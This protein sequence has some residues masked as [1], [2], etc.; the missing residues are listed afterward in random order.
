MQTEPGRRT[1]AAS[2]RQEGGT[3]GRLLVRLEVVLAEAEND[4]RLAHGRL[5]CSHEITLVSVASPHSAPA[6]L[7]EVHSPV[8]SV[9]IDER[10]GGKAEVSGIIRTDQGVCT[11]SFRSLSG[12]PR[13]PRAT[14]RCTSLR[15]MNEARQ[16]RPRRS[17]AAGRARRTKEDKLDLHGTRRRLLGL[18]LLAHGEVPMD[19]AAKSPLLLEPSTRLQPGA[20]LTVLASTYTARAPRACT[21]GSPG[22]LC[23][24]PSRPRSLHP[25][26]ASAFRLVAAVDRLAEGLLGSVSTS[27][28]LASGCLVVALVDP[29]AS[30]LLRSGCSAFLA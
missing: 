27:A 2:L 20:V 23:S 7:E 10:G 30:V 26:L 21:G 11:A 15:E 12:P 16:S 9:T 24:R 29:L 8:G 17:R 5:A 19:N 3:D 25:P 14:A 6:A 28:A 4:R 22:P 1:K 13:S 18:F